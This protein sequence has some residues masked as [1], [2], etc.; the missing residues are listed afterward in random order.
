MITNLP[1]MWDTLVQSLC[2]E[3]PLEKGMTTYSNIL[4]VS[5]VAQIVKN[6]PA[7]QETRVWSWGQED[8]LEKEV[9]TYSNNSCLENSKGRGAWQATVHGVIKGQIGRD[10]VTKTSTFLILLS[11]PRMRPF[12][13]ILWNLFINSLNIILGPS[14]CQIWHWD[15]GT[16]W[17]TRLH[18]FM[19]HSH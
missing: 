17:W 5:L 12:H 4:G 19:G 9:A 18:F 15:L 6:L 7:M 2:W 13:K 1:S 16:Q 3:D 11:A 10:W 8:P 14:V